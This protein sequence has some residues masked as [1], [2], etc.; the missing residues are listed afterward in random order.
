VLVCVRPSCSPN[1]SRNLDE[2]SVSAA[3]CHA[4]L[5]A[6]RDVD[7]GAI[8]ARRSA[9]SSVGGGEAR[10]ARASWIAALD[11]SVIPS[12]VA[13]ISAI[14]AAR[15][16]RSAPI[17]PAARGDRP[18]SSRWV[19][20]ASSVSGFSISV[21]VRECHASPRGSATAAT[22]EPVESGGRSGTPDPRRSPRSSSADG[23][24]GP[25]RSSTDR[26]FRPAKSRSRTKD[27]IPRR[28]SN[29]EMSFIDDQQAS[30]N[31]TWPPEASFRGRPTSR[32]DPRFRTRPRRAIP[33]DQPPFPSCPAAQGPV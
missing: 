10:S 26:R 9:T 1:L 12:N 30:V 6:A 16:L 21:S 5:S 7:A 4:T 32:Q 24:A 2:Y 8:E 14:P 13:L 29:M 18:S 27:Q 23:P 19:C 17:A 22:A 20:S 28:A 15:S 25:M 11:T 31:V 3:E 33:A